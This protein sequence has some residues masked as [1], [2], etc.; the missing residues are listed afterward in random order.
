MYHVAICDDSEADR[1]ALKKLLIK[2]DVYVKEVILHEYESGNQLIEAM[3]TIQFS[4]IFLD[5]RMDGMSGRETAYRIRERD[6]KVVLAFITGSVEPASDVFRVTPYRYMIKTAAEEE[7]DTD[8]KSIIA[9]MISTESIPRIKATVDKQ[10]IR[11]HPNDILYIEKY[12]RKSRVHIT[13]SAIMEYRLEKKG[14]VLS[15]MKLA[16]IY[17]CLKG[18]GF[19]WPHDSYIINFKYVNTLAKDYL[20]LEGVPAKFTITRSKTKEFGKQKSYFL[21]GKYNGGK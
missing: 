19:G 15:G 6:S 9:Q 4:L 11:I 5:M 13:Q 8:I 12:E 3:K 10:I 16:D 2:N 7:L 17:E 1:L 21:L 14:D 18:Y 20:F